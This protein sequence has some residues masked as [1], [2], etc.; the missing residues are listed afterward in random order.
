MKTVEDV[1]KRLLNNHYR[2]TLPYG[3]NFSPERTAYQVEEARLYQEF[4]DDAIS[5]HGLTGHPKAERAF[6]L[7]WE[8]GHSAGMH[9]VFN[10][11][12]K[13]ASLLKD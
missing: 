5:A 8:D 2:N 4:K 3:N 9:E 13:Y 10:C 11:M 1:T 7:A 6:S 12:F